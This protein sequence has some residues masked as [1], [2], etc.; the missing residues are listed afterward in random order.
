MIDS[1]MA[2]FAE[3]P[4]RPGLIP[5]LDQFCEPTGLP[6]W[7]YQLGKPRR[8][9]DG[10][11]RSF[12][13]V[14]PLPAFA[15]NKKLT[16]FG[17]ANV[18]D[19]FKVSLPAVLYGS[20]CHLLCSQA[21]IDAALDIV[22][23]MLA[24]VV[25]FDVCTAGVHFTR[26]DLVLN[27]APPG[28]PPAAFFASMRNCRHSRI[29]RD[30]IRYTVGEVPSGLVLK[31][32]ELTIRAYD[33]ALKEWGRAGH[34][35]R[36]ELELRRGVLQ[37]FLGNA[38]GGY[39]NRIDFD[40]C[41]RTYRSLL[42]PLDP[43]RQLTLA[44][45]FRSSLDF[46]ALLAAHYENEGITLPGGLSPVQLYRDS[47]SIQS[48]YKFRDR[49]NAAQFSLNEISFAEL[50]PEEWPANHLVYHVDEAA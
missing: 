16:L 25:D 23:E 24:R 40:R 2:R 6:G 36:I 39:P 17:H 35:T 28:L 27:F 46:A 12:F 5:D 1:I 7:V 15:C 41:Y 45:P 8:R 14:A 33:K 21:E 34:V 10:A 9:S 37:D 20:N 30:M 3:L 4:L 13:L 29:R 26:M 47:F 49:V 48:F 22:S 11:C 18:I 44:G 31:S 42:L 43:V 19:G 38:N 50:L 32:G